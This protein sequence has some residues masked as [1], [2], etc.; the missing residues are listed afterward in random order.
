M[1]RIT[2]TLLLMLFFFNSQSQSM[3]GQTDYMYGTMGNR[4]ETLVGYF[5]FDYEISQNGQT[6]YFW[7]GPGSGR[8]KSFQSRK[9]DYFRGDSVYMEKF[10]GYQALGGKV[11]LL[12]PRIVDGRIQ[13]FELF[14][15]WGP[16]HLAKSDRY[17]VKKGEEKFQ[18]KKKK[19][20]EQMK[21]LINEDADLLKKVE[22]GELT[23]DNLIDVILMYNNK[24]LSADTNLQ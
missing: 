9:Y 17:F 18:L 14:F 10:G 15:K 1:R 6:V 23:Y 7:K 5:S 13:L 24:I 21:S 3:Y 12:I 19:F 2:F 4:T 8:P 16:G 11:E 22:S 20:K